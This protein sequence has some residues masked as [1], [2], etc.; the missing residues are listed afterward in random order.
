MAFSFAV[1]ASASETDGGKS[2]S[3][4]VNCPSRSLMVA[5]VG[6][7]NVTEKTSLSSSI[8]SAKIGILN[9]LDVSPGLKVSVPLEVV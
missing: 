3:K 5:L 9:V 7:D 6:D 1:E 2:S 8:V 4:I